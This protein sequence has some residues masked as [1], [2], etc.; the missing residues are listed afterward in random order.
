MPV[1]DLCVGKWGG[2]LTAGGARTLPGCPSWQGR[3]KLS[4]EIKLVLEV[5]DALLV[6]REFPT[7]KGRHGAGGF[8]IPQK[9]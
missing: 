9:E 1:R 4:G 2:E 6:T 7:D 5:L 8:K 3:F